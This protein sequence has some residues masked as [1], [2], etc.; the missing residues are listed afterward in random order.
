MLNG[1]FGVGKTTTALA[2]AE[3]IPGAHLFDPETVGHLARYITSG[4]RHGAEDT[5]DFQDIRI[6][7]ALTVATAQQ[8]Y[9]TYARPLIV[10]MTLAHPAVFHPIRDGFGAFA[11]VHH[12]C[13]V[14]PLATIQQRLQDRGEGPGSWT[15]RKAEQYVPRLADPCYTTHIDTQRHAVP[16]VVDQLLAHIGDKTAFA[17]PE[18]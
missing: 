10:P 1:S 2:L 9:E 14:A 15:W 11:P 13:L 16:A 7:P 18:R 6:W 5:D 3:Q 8:L 4:L 17:K 12:F